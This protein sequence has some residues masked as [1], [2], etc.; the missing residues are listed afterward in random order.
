MAKADVCPVCG[1]EG[2]ITKQTCGITTAAKFTVTCHG[3][4]GKGWVE[5]ASGY[6]RNSN[7]GIVRG[8]PQW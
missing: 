3:C 8:V 4:G 7:K 2:R 5:V 1:G 6:P